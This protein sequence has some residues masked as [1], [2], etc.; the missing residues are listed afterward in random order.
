M[1]KTISS[2]LVADCLESG[3]GDRAAKASTAMRRSEARAAENNTKQ[4][5]GRPGQAT[6]DEQEQP[7]QASQCA[8]TWF[9]RSWLRTTQSSRPARD[10]RDRNLEA[11]R[12]CSE[13]A[14]A[15]ETQHGPTCRT[16]GAFPHMVTQIDSARQ[17]GVDS[18]DA[19]AQEKLSA[20]ATRAYACTLPE[21]PGQV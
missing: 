1:A 8:G 11:R 9:E 5:P 10:S 21:E 20:T 19:C 17:H 2:C 13:V 15:H 3:A 6:A 7:N 14:Q 18:R 12:A 16:L 4:Q